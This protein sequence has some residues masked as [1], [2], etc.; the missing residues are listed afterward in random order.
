[1]AF[2]APGVSGGNERNG[3][4]T[5]ERYSSEP[6]AFEHARILPDRMIALIVLRELAR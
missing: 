6:G 2:A 3:K 4:E 5:D 1:M